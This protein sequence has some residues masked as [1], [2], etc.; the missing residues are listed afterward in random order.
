MKRS[1]SSSGNFVRSAAL[2]DSAW[3]GGSAWTAP[4]RGDAPNSA[5][6][7]VGGGAADGGA[8][9]S[10][11]HLRVKIAKCH[12]SQLQRMAK[13][14]ERS[15]HDLENVRAN[16]LRGVDEFAQDVNR[17]RCERCERC[18]GGNPCLSH[19]RQCDVVIFAYQQLSIAMDVA[20]AKGIDGAQM[21]D[22]QRRFDALEE[23]RDLLEDD[24][25][26][27]TRFLAMSR[28]FV[29]EAPCWPACGRFSNPV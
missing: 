23:N 19:I 1:D 27:L 2:I 11:V 22:L 29:I 20:F 5:E 28:A 26:L 21:K 4:A 16:F 18:E 12:L 24:S 14:L 17:K 3:G 10:F 15:T 9:A 8:E 6:R 13:D 7:N 25:K